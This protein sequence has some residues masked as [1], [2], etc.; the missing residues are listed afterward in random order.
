[1]GAT[2]RLGGRRG[3]QLRSTVHA[4]HNGRPDVYE[5]DGDA[6][7]LALAETPF[8]SVDDAER[9]LGELLSAFEA[10]DDRRAVFL[11]IYLQMTE[12]VRQRIRDGAFG[13][14]DWVADYLVEFAN[15]YRDAVYHYENGDLEAVADPWQLAFDAADGGDSLV[16]QDAALGINAHINYDLAFAVNEV[17]VKPG[18]ELKYDDHCLVTD[19]IRDIIDDAQETLVDWGAEGFD[20]FSDSVGRLDEWLTVLTID[21]C[22][23]S[24]WRTANALNS[25]LGVRRRWAR[26]INDVT[27]TGAAYLILSSKASG[28]VHETLVDF[29]GS[30]E[31]S[32]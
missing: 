27:S 21:E 31:G 3:K 4:V 26:W 6:E 10:R 16:V 19:V 7:L 22:R 5:R 17:G 11:S 2:A 9:R 14:P 12:A 25:R 20:S 8:S 30:A 28:L 32:G 24:A 18:P 1:M 29:E 15:R 23:D 13:Y